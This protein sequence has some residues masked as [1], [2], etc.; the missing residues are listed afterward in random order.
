MSS[1]FRLFLVRHGETDWNAEKRYLGQTDLPLNS[2]GRQQ[3]LNLAH[4]LK[5]V[6][7]ACCY[8][9]DLI[10]ASQT[11]STILKGRDVEIIIEIA[12]REASF[13]TWE[14]LTH[15]EISRQHA[16]ELELWVESQGMTKPGGGESLG[17]LRGRLGAWLESLYA[18]NPAGNILVV[19]HGGPLRVILCLLMGLPVT[20]HWKF[21]VEPS[22]MTVVEIHDGEA[23][24]RIGSS[25]APGKRR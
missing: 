8:T 5:D 6:D 19:T 22:A 10:R 1:I 7:F 2:K 15:A 4:E 13:G 16:V 18:E 23:I 24:L 11:T 9:S 14:G 21:S 20:K 3:V 12:L 17:D 25:I